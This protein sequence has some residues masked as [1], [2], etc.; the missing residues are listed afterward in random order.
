MQRNLD[1]RVETLFPLEDPALVTYVHDEILCTSLRD[2]VRARILR[3]DGTYI[4]AQPNNGDQ[5]ID[6]QAVFSQG[7]N[8]PPDA[9][10]HSVLDDK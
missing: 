9:V 6:S 5:A 8:V 4:W 2:N 3:P 1:R 7:R 10:P